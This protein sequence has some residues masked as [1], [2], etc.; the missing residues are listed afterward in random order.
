MVKIF[1]RKTPVELGYLQVEKDVKFGTDSLDS[2]NVLFNA[3]HLRASWTVQY[4]SLWL[5][6]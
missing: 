2:R 3:S 4:K 5:K 6:K 1:G